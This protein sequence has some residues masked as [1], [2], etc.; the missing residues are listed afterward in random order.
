MR[1]EASLNEEA[2]CASDFTLAVA[3][4]GS[5]DVG[6]ECRGARGWAN[7]KRREE[8]QERGAERGD[9]EREKAKLGHV[10]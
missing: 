8:Q 9:E 7:E 6:V 4:H 3:C 2:V 5:A 1:K 10:H